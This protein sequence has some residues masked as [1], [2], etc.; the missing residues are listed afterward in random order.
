VYPNLTAAE[1]ASDNASVAAIRTFL[2]VDMRGYTRFI[3]EHG[4]AQAAHLVEKFDVMALKAFTARHGEIVGKAGDEAVA[5]FGSAREAIRAAVQLQASFAEE[6][7]L[8]PA[9]PQVG[10]GLDTGEAVPVGDTFVG[11]AL[12]L[13]AR[14]CKLAGPQEVLA[15]ESVIH[16][17]GKLDDVT[18]AER[19]FTQLKGFQEPVHVFQVIDGRQVSTTKS[20]G[21]S[22][23]LTG[24]STAPLPIGAP[25][26]PPGYGASCPR[27]GAEA[28]IDCCRCGRSR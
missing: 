11:V 9:L 23:P 6:G 13:A 10:I 17:A 24:P 3:V 28:G 26:G 4:D 16:V 21:G 2:F 8:N 18:Y 25:G 15:S 14:L 12:N 27:R 20:S 5:V 1:Q 7:K 19:G 22:A